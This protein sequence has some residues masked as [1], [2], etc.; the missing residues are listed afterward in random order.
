MPL[1]RR[2]KQAR[3]CAKAPDFMH[4]LTHKYTL[5][6]I[7]RVGEDTLKMYLRYRYLRAVSSVS[8]DTLDKNTI[9]KNG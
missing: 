8:L 6:S 4:F 1:R 5:L 3:D 9:N 7:F 2:G